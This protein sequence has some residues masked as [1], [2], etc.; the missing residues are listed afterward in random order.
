MILTFRKMV[1]FIVFLR[2]NRYFLINKWSCDANKNNGSSFP[3]CKLW[4]IKLIAL[5]NYTN[6]IIYWFIVSGQKR[7]FI[8]YYYLISL[9]RVT[10]PG[11]KQIYST[12]NTSSYKTSILSMIRFNSEKSRFESHRSYQCVCKW[13]Y[14]MHDVRS[15]KYIQ[16]KTFPISSFRAILRVFGI[17]VSIY[18]YY[19]YCSLIS[20]CPALHSLLLLFLLLLLLV[21]LQALHECLLSNDQQHTYNVWV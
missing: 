2:T 10:F 21:T 20:I 16:K 3:E 9:F 14:S 5:L 15:T 8:D 19:C 11:E 17:P 4:S 7:S 18:I 13:A 12:Q 6:N 1:N